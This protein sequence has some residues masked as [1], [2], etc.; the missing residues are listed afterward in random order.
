MCV[1]KSFFASLKVGTRRYLA[2][3]ILDD[4]LDVNHFDSWK[5][6]DV[7]SLGLVLWELGRRTSVGGGIFE[8]YQQPYFE[9]VGP[10]PTMEEMRL[11]VCEKQIRPV[12]SNRWESSEVRSASIEHAQ[13]RLR[14]PFSLLLQQLKALSKVIKE[15]WYANAP[16]RLTALRIKKTLA[17]LEGN[18][19]N[20]QKYQ[21][22]N[23]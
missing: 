14:K 21:I 19:T 10:D 20:K 2:P 5:R 4:S 3:E 17:Q 1:C 13:Y 8:T 6:A 16:A 12:C 9:V 7:F 23:T 22:I 11:V 18:T 15:C